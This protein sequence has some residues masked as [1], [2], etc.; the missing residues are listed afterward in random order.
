MMNNNLD[1]IELRSEKTAITWLGLGLALL[2]ALLYTLFYALVLANAEN[3]PFLSAL[4]G[5]LVSTAIKFLLL[6]GSWYLIVREGHDF[7]SWIKLLLH[8]GVAVVYSVIWYYGYLYLFDLFFGIEHLQGGGF[9]ENRM[10]VIFSAFFEYVI[11]FSIFHIIDSIRKLK[12]RERQAAELRELSNRQRIANLKAQL[13]PHFLFNTLNSINAMVSKDVDRTR[14]MIARLS[15]M[16]RY[17]LKSFEREKVSLREELNFVEKYLELE[18]HRF[19]ERLD[20]EINVDKELV[21][22]EVPPMTIQP[23]VENAVK[24]GISSSDQGGTVTVEVSRHREGMKVEVTDTGQGVSDFEQLKSS[25][26]IGIRNT[27]KHLKKRY[28]QDSAL[29]FDSVD[30]E[31]TKVWFSIPLEEQEA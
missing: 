25:D 16:L 1:A 29:Q 28:G 14:S 3:V 20:Y 7:S 27:D 31:G 15:E 30:S 13:N 19:G 9:I 4:L 12:E 11:V 17:S 10:W 24:H 22:V 8:L 26:G 23:L 5:T 6:F 18:K 21:N 2:I